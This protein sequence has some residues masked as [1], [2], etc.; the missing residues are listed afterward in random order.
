MEICDELRDRPV[1]DVVSVVSNDSAYY[2][3]VIQDYMV[4]EWRCVDT[5]NL[6]G[7]EVVTIAWMHQGTKVREHHLE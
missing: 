4:N 1:P 3:C 5:V 6:G 2:V 7:E